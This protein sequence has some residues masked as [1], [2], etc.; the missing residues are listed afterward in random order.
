MCY[1]K[2]SSLIAGTIAYLFAAAIYARN[3]GDDRWVA[4]FIFTYSTV[5][6]LEAGVWHSIENNSSRGNDIFTRLLLIAIWMQPIVMSLCAIYLGQSRGT[7]LNVALR[8]T[9]M[10][11]VVFLFKSLLRVFDCN[12]H[13]E[14]QIGE[15]GHLA[16]TDQSGDPN[17]FIDKQFPRI[18]KTIYMVGMFLPYIFMPSFTAFSA[19]S[20]IMAATIAG[21]LIYNYVMYYHTGEFSSMWC[22]HAIAVAVMAYF[23][24]N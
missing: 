1:D 6:F 23:V 4:I 9:L 3:Q 18:S 22:Y 10:L 21:S 19:R 20:L 2:K 14:S 5:Q 11:S 8:A 15:N 13:F 24:N 7:V 12:R 16:W 17:H